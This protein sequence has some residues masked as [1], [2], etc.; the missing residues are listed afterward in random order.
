MLVARGEW[1][2]VWVDV[3]KG[4]GDEDICNRVRHKN[5]VKKRKKHPNRQIINTKKQ[6]LRKLMS[7]STMNYKDSAIFNLTNT[8]SVSGH[9]FPWKGNHCSIC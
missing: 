9:T 3:G 8:V 4:G 1:G 2:G 7:A 5:E 6:E